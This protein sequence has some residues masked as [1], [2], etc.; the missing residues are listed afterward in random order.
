MPTDPFDSALERLTGLPGG[1][2]VQPVVVQTRDFYGHSTSWLVQVVKTDEGDNVFL[3]SVSAS[4]QAR[5]V[6]PARV[7]Q[8]IDRQRATVSTKVRRRH[9]RRLAEE[10]KARGEQPGFLKKGKTA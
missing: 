2:H 7:L 6:I 4:G 1:A 3:Q 10:R 5:I 8:T 9:G